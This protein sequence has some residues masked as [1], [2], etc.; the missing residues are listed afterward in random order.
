MQNFDFNHILELVKSHQ[1]RELKAIFNDMNEVDIAQ[2]LE[3]L[4]HEDLVYAFLTLDKDTAS[5]VFAELPGDIQEEIITSI[6]D[7]EL[8]VI[9][10]DLAVDDAVDMLDEMPSNVVTRVL[11]NAHP[12]TRAEINQFLKYPDNSAGSVMTAEFTSLHATMTVKDAIAHIRSYGEDRETIYS[13]YVIDKVHKLLGV[14]SVKDLLLSNDTVLVGDLMDTSVISV[15]TLEDQEEAAR[16]LDKYDLLALPVVDSEN[17]LV[18]IITIDDALDVL[19]QETT[20]DMQLMAATAPSEEPYLKTSI[21]E[22]A[23]N[24]IVW[25]MVLMISDMVSGGILGTFE[26]ALTALPVLITFIPMLTDTGGNAGSQSSTLVIRGLALKEINISDFFPV[27]TKE[28][29][30]AMLCGFVLS[31]FNFIR[32]VIVYPGNYFL[33]ITVAG[34]MFCTVLMAKAIGGVLPIIATKFDMD[35]ALMASPLITTIVDAGSLLIYL[36]IAKMCLTL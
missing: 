20:E 14:V 12:E 28:I 2:C 4:S 8:S 36:N 19:K 31:L 21:L 17:R 32:I 30:V 13:C 22:L 27:L 29:G 15:T 25:L 6:T 11:K 23:K 5:D 1:F 18:G 9:I 3:E 24:R 7:Q 34:A 35:P 33:A 26:D 16:L 10:E